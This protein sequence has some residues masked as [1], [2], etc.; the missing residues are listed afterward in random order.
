M[1]SRKILFLLMVCCLFLT[2][3]CWDQKVMQDTYY[4]VAMGADYKDN[5]YI[6]YLQFMDFSEVAKTEQGKASEKVPLWIVT[7]TGQTWPDALLH[8]VAVSPQQFVLSH[9]DSVILTDRAIEHGMNQIMDWIRR[10]PEFR[11]TGHIFGT[12]DDLKQILSASPLF[13]LAPLT[14]IEHTPETVAKQHAYIP[15]LQVFDFNRQ[16]QDTAST[17]LL[18]TLSITNAWLEEDKPHPQPFI[19]GAFIY[20]HR[21][22]RNWMSRQELSGYRWVVHN[23][24][25]SMLRV[26][27]DPKTPGLEIAVWDVKPSFKVRMKNGNPVF[28][29]H[30][31]GKSTLLAQAGMEENMNEMIDK[32]IQK[33]IVSTFLSG[34]NQRV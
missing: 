30:V 11:M 15:P 13:N 16:Y 25:R 27:T 26:Q 19:Y 7:G 6:A 3:G 12:K 2:T 10:Y 4:A 24:K 32:E 23:T 28:D 34:I 29:V 21:K 5:K 18:P 9:V 1:T 17:V 20:Q 22:Y 33:Q 8:I 31:K 14:L